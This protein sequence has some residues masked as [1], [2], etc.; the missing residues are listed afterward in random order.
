[1]KH[2]ADCDGAQKS[3]E[4]VGCIMKGVE[5]DTEYNIMPL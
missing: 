4:I 1:M 3:S 2:L 5:S